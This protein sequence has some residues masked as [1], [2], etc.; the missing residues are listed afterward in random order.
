MAL[1][2]SP[3]RKPN[4]AESDGAL[5]VRDVG[6][7]LPYIICDILFKRR[8]PACYITSKLTFIFTL[9]FLLSQDL[10]LASP[11]SPSLEVDTS[12]RKVVKVGSITIRD[13]VRKWVEG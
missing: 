11:D 13:N 1:P 4:R 2:L 6:Y 8:L 9:T 5:T 10:G 3:L 12:G 7:T